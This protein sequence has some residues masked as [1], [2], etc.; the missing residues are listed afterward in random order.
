MAV[1]QGGFVM[2]GAFVLSWFILAALVL[3]CIA[4]FW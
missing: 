2:V 1:V 4:A 3:A